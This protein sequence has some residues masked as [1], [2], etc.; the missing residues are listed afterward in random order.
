MRSPSDESEHHE[1]TRVTFR[2]E[3]TAV[4]EIESLVDQGVYKNQSEAIRDAVSTHI[5]TPEHNVQ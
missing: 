3:Q 4:N 5:Q 1:T 2:I